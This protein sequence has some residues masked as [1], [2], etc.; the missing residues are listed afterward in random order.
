MNIEH[1][2]LNVE[3]VYNSSIGEV[4]DEAINSLLTVLQPVIP[5]VIN[6]VTN[7][8]GIELNYVLSLLG[9][10][11]IQFGKTLLEPEN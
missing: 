7:T 4:S 3:K 5:T 8:K 2:E 9:L 10:N 11:W 6:T 1:F